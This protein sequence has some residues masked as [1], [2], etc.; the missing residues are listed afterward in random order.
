MTFNYSDRMNGL[1][2]SATRE[3]FKLLSR[4]EIIS[5]AGGLP[6]NEYLPVKEVNEILDE[7]LSSP[8]AAKS[9]QY[10]S[11][12]GFPALR[13]ILTDYVR[14]VGITDAKV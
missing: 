14:H 7:I 10:G 9:L 11:T 5:F 12:E 6:A 2:G 13:E 3:I 4:P 1:D 8:M